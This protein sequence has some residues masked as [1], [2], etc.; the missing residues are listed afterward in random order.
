MDLKL[1]GANVVV[2]GGA[3]GIGASIV[4][5]FAREGANVYFCS[6]SEDKVHTL[7]EQLSALPG[8]CRGKAL[9]ISDQKAFSQ[10][11][12]D[13]GSIDVYVPN[14]AS[15]ARDWETAAAV[16][17]KANAEN[18]EA[19]LPYLRQ[20]KIPAI[21][22]IGS[23][24]AHVSMLNM[25]VYAATKAAVTHYM[26][27]LSHR[28]IGEGI[29][30]NTVAP[31]EVFVKDGAWDRVKRDNPDLYKAAMAANPMGRFAEAHEIAA[32]VVF[33]SSP[34]SSFTSGSILVVDGCRTQHVQG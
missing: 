9:D 7:Q 12:S 29:R 21:T 28:L 19:I 30:V 24:A 14:A 34:Q 31:G 2:T 11:L 13:I 5:A 18:I 17:M 15:F 22:Y 26:K 4:E 10:W 16:D 32:S 20:S 27:S 6:R 1:T 23:I 8:Q 25:E 3:A 33:L